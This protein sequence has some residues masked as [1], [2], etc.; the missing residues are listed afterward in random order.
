MKHLNTMTFQ[1]RSPSSVTVSYNNNE[2]L[3]ILNRFSSFENK[4]FNTYLVVMNDP[5]V[6]NKFM[7]SKWSL[8]MITLYTEPFAC[9]YKR[10]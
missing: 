7:L 5:Q 4:V 1:R 3:S 6:F 2:N 10:K 9:T 8:S